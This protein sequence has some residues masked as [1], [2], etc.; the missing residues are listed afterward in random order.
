MR[1]LKRIKLRGKRKFRIWIYPLFVILLYIVISYNFKGIKLENNNSDFVKQLLQESNSHLVYEKQ[2]KDLFSK[3][4]SFINHVEIENPPTII[5]RVFAYNEI[6]EV[7]PQGFYYIQN[8]VV[9]HPRVYIY[10]TH[11]L[12]GYVGEKLEGYDVS[13]GVLLASILL[14]EKLNEK[15]IATIVEER[16][17][18]N[19]L[20]ENNLSFEQS[21]QATRSFLKDQLNQHNDFDLIIDLHRDATSKDKSTTTIDD[22]E[23]AKVMFVMRES[24]PNVKFAESLNTIIENKYPSLS[25]G[26]YKKYVDNFNQDLNKKTILLELGGNY[27]TIDEVVNTIDALANSIEEFL[28]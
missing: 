24:Y 7:E 4:L 14:Q 12:E 17:V 1:I 11:P 13:P 10:S 26:I 25:R 20:K 16:S 22:K 23:Y 18:S 8:N 2:H 15:G 9:D 5:D 28:K 3:F 21:Y 27:N 6:E 19:Y